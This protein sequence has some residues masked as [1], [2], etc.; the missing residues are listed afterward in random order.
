MSTTAPMPMV[1][2]IAVPKNSARYAD[3][4]RFMHRLLSEGSGVRKR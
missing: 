4:F 2:M 3:Q 1:I